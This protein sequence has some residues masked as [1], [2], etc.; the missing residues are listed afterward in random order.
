MRVRRVNARGAAAVAMSGCL[1]LAI[2]CSEIASPPTA[3]PA[4]RLS[5]ATGV[6]A[7][8]SEN[9]DLDQPDLLLHYKTMAGNIVDVIP[10][11]GSA[12]STS[13]PDNVRFDHFTADGWVVVYNTFDVNQTNER[14]VMM[15]YNKY[16][17]ILRWWWW[18]DQQPPGPSN[19]LTY[20]LM[21]DGNSTSALNFVGE[22]AKDYTV[23]SSHPFAVKAVNGQLDAVED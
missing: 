9:I 22:F 18:N 23:Q 5:P 13:A 19:Y 15:L 2:A 20:A 6:D 7:V 17:G 1:L 8:I 4:A 10:P 16:R 3:P 12:A 11:W 21:I 14:P